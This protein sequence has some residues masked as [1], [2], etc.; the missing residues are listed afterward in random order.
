MRC[1]NETAGG[2]TMKNAIHNI[3]GL[4]EKLRNAAQHLI[5][6]MGDAVSTE[7]RACFYQKLD[8]QVF[9]NAFQRIPDLGVVHMKFFCKNSV[10]FYISFFRNGEVIM[11]RTRDSLKSYMTFNPLPEECR[12]EG[13]I[14][15]SHKSV[16]IMNPPNLRS[17]SLCRLGTELMFKMGV[18]LLILGG[19]LKELFPGT[20]QP[21]AHSAKRGLYSLGGNARNGWKSLGRYITERFGIPHDGKGE[22]Y[23]LGRLLT[24]LKEPFFM[25]MLGSIVKLSALE[26]AELSGAI[27]H[28]HFWSSLQHKLDSHM[29]EVDGQSRE[30]LTALKQHMPQ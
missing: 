16:T 29:D 19:G 6:K 28:A 13:F 12:L 15:R 23:V 27:G 4:A 30:A 11:N 26:I 7:A 14:N 24:D 22:E 21:T 2:S 20:F 1:L 5:E 3:A 18:V 9:Q 17:A 25:S 8:Y 10:E